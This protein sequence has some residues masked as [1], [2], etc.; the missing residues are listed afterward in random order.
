MKPVGD[1]YGVAENVDDSRKT[2][3]DLIAAHPDL[4][5]FLAFG[6]QGPIGAGR[7][8]EEKGDVGKVFVV[9]PFSPGQGRKL[10]KD[11]AITGGFMWNPAEAGRVFVRVGKMLANGQEIKDGDDDR[12]ARRRPSRSEDPQHH[13]RQPPADQQG[14]GRQARRSRALTDP[15]LPR[16]RERPAPGGA[17]AFDDN[18]ELAVDNH[19]GAIA[20]TLCSRLRGDPLRARVGPLRRRA[21]ARRR[22][23]F[24]R[25]RGGALPRRRERQRQEHAH[26]GHRRRLPGRRPARAPTISARASRRR[27]RSSPARK[28]VA[29]IWQ[30][31]A[32][33]PE[34]TV[35]ENIAFDGLVGAPRLVN[36]RAMRE[37]ARAALAKLGVEL[38]LS[39]PLKSLP[40]SGKTTGGDRTRAR[41]RR[42]AHLH[43]R[44]HGLAHTDRDGPLARRRAHALR[45]RRRRGFCQPSARGGARRVEPR[46]RSA[47]RSAGRRVSTPRA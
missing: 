4:K 29:V 5:G 2:A 18:P 21:R 39:A 45:L 32:L 26:Q 42:K 46:H 34:M 41:Q 31:L 7:A 6:S 13:H 44:A 9:G 3:L 24:G 33:F 10:I 27:R 15:P 36:Y 8:I 35:A 43:G 30:D 11:G 40:I 17:E 28:G 1:R 20:E 14:H 16:K 12:R 22:V 19:D 38:D 23:V 25:A 47:R 37:T